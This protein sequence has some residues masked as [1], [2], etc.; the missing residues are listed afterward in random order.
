MSPAE[1]GEPP[2]YDGG[3]ASDA[4]RG[5][6]EPE[7]QPPAADPEV[8]EALDRMEDEREIPDAD[9]AGE[10]DEDEPE[11]QANPDDTDEGQAP[12]G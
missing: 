4:P 1:P 12:T 2:T 11:E 7:S 10:R 8:R 9:D 3:L 5:D 6:V